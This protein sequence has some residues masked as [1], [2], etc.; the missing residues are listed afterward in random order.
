M[1]RSSKTPKATERPIAP[2]GSGQ[3]L[4]ALNRA[5]GAMVRAGSDVQQHI[6][7]SSSLIQQ[8][9][10]RKLRLATTPAEFFTVQAAFV[11]ASW[12]QSV[13]CS[14]IVAKAWTEALRQP[15]P[16]H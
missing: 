1:S 5:T 15:R 11:V 7:R 12:Q 14:S 2:T 16:L 4:A 8:E 13:E 3:P 6:A 10:A 9:A